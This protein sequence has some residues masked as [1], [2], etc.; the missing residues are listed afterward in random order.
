MEKTKSASDNISDNLGRIQKKNKKL[1]TE[2]AELQ[3]VVYGASMENQELEKEKR[4]AVQDRVQWT[5]WSI[6]GV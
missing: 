4:G 5:I 3:H 1:H 2:I 6:T